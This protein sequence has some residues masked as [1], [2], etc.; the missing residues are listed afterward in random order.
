MYW[1][2]WISSNKIS[3]SINVGRDNDQINETIKL[4]SLTKVVSNE[5]LNPL[6]TDHEAVLVQQQKLLTENAL[7][8]S[9]HF[10]YWKPCF[11]NFY[12]RSKTIECAFLFQNVFLSKTAAKR[13][14]Y[15]T[16]VN[17]SLLTSDESIITLGGVGKGLT[18]KG[19]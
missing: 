8:E 6:C 11:L 12:A 18:S 2:T 7:A 14:N 17:D 16:A 9:N 4:G 1:R 10:S 3:L 13:S 19:N 5:I 15:T